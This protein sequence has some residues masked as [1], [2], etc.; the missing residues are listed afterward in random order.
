MIYNV[1]DQLRKLRKSKKLSQDKLAGLINSKFDTN[2]NKG[3]IS[4][5][6]NNKEMP[7]SDNM[8]RLTQVLDC[9]L[10][11]IMGFTEELHSD[12]NSDTSTTS[13]MAEYFEQ[14]KEKL[15]SI[16]KEDSLRLIKLIN[17]FIN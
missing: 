7:T 5:W 11:Y 6:E 12:V 9:D 4:K 2:V 16:N 14:N 15:S 3:M 13:E 8:Y 10:S 17:A 1:G